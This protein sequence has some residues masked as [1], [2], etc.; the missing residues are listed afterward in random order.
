MAD[1]APSPVLAGVTCR[2]PRCGEGKLFD[3]YLTLAKRCDNCGLDLAFADSGDGPAVFVI[4]IVGFLVVGGA[5][6]TEVMF[7]PPYW[8]HALIWA[9]LA[10]G[11]PL[12]LLRP[13]KG[14][15][16]AVQYRHDAAGK[17][18]SD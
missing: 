8:L 17:S 6:V 5:L 11:L 3:G 15:M 7:R 4:F 18:L 12:L 9:P 2:C 13:A 1:P 16:V 10:I 14:L